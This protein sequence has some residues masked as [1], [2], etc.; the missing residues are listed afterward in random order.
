MR[1]VNHLTQ[2]GV[3]VC[4]VKVA[5]SRYQKPTGKNI[6]KKFI[7]LT[8]YSINRHYLK[9]MESK[10]DEEEHQMKWYCA[11]VCAMSS[12]CKYVNSCLCF[13]NW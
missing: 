6:G 8:N 2:F 4:L 11:C 13:I 1:K 12:L 7:H 5:Y 3:L 10:A 9:Y